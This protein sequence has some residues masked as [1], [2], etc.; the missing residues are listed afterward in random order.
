MQQPRIWALLDD[1]PGHQT[2]VK[3][4]AGRLGWPFETRTLS[5]NVL[6]HLPNPL[7]GAS[8]LAVD[9]RKSDPLAPPFPDIVITMGRRCLPVARWIKRA[10]AGRTKL[11]HIGRKG[12]TAADE[13]ALLISCAHFNMPPHAH[14]LAVTLPPTQVTKACLAKAREEW[15]ALLAERRAPHVV[16]LVGGE[17]AL[18]SFP[19]DHAVDLLKR[20]EAATAALGGSLTVVTSRRTSPDAVKAMQD[21]AE[22]AVF[23]LWKRHQTCNPYLG[24]LAWAD[25]LIVTGESE[26]MLAEA[27]A[28]GAPLHIAPMPGK[29]PRAMSRLKCRM[30]FM[31]CEQ[32]DGMANL[33]RTLFNSGWMT[34]SRDL[35]KMHDLMYEAGLA[36][37]FG[38]D[39]CLTPPAENRTSEQFVDRM[40]D[41]L[42]S[43]THP[44]LQV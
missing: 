25:G 27:A 31:A 5:F 6:N 33:C 2:Q 11:V 29:Q 35:E 23:H 14:R 37:P 26:L 24:Y 1:R 13:F 15:P 32:H 30:T 41:I 36:R 40:T 17:T 39:I 19:A 10:S 21:A 44:S 34:P 4:L 12:V 43:L 7:M 9:R 3:G 18:H 8:L 38:S 16:F 28:T 20:A 42:C 22:H